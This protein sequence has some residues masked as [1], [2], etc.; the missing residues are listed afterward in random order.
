M[1]EATEPHVAWTRSLFEGMKPFSEGKVYVNFLMDEGQDRVRAA[2][3][4]EKYDQLVAI[5]APL[6][7]RQLLPP[8]PERRSGERE[9]SAMTGLNLMHG[10]REMRWEPDTLLINTAREIAPIA[11]THSEEA[12]RE[13]RLSQPVLKALREMGLLRW[14]DEDETR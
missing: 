8:Q 5:K 14:E 13:R 11:R 9:V 12:E 2:Y 4:P 7:P 1:G 10:T 6:R 3:G